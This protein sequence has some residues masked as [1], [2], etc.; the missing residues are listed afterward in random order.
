MENASRALIIAGGMLIA[1]LIVG[2]LVLGYTEIRDYQ[3]SQTD[4][5]AIAQLAEFN[6]RFEAY[7]RTTVRGYQIISLGNL[8]YDTNIRYADYQGYE[9]VV[10]EVTGLTKLYKSDSNPNEKVN[11]V[12][13]VQ[14]TYD[15]LNSNQQN[16]IKEAYFECTGITYGASGRVTGMQFSNVEVVN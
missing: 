1:M 5:E 4:E 16:A 10:V 3:Q 12:D 9:R 15:R 11:I 2:L 14:N 13:F 6:E 7:N 8:V